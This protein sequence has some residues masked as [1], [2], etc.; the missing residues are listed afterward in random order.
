MDLRSLGIEDPGP[1]P[2]LP[3]ADALEDLARVEERI[4]DLVGESTRAA[5]AGHAAAREVE[6]TLARLTASLERSRRRERRALIAAVLG[7]ALFLGL[8]AAS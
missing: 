3:E 4:R 5:L 6:R 2:R 8:L 7:W 1:L